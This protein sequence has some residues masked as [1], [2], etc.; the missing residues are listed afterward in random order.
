[1]N[2]TKAITTD[3]VDQAF[4]V[5]KR[6]SVIPLRNADADAQ[7]FSAMLFVASGGPM[8]LTGAQYIEA[9]LALANQV[10]SSDQWAAE[11]QALVNLLDEIRKSPS[12]A[13]Q[14]HKAHWLERLRSRVL[15]IHGFDGEPDLQVVP[16]E[17]TAKAYV[18]RLLTTPQFAGKLRRCET[19]GNFFLDDEIRTGQRKNYCSKECTRTGTLEKTRERARQWRIDH[20]ASKPARKP[21]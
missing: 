6:V 9:L 1:M 18:L 12:G 11:R 5:I 10:E 7:Q 15:T 19:C 13:Y 8:A 3:A 16:D 14:R 4:D 2:V 21:K 17:K 20:K